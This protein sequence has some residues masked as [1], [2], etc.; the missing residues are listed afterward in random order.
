MC[1]GFEMKVRQVALVVVCPKVPFKNM[2]QSVTT[3][4]NMAYTFSEYTYM[5]LDCTKKKFRN[6]VFQ[7]TQRLLFG[8]LMRVHHAGFALRVLK[9]T[10]FGGLKKARIQPQDPKPVILTLLARPASGESCLNNS[11]THTTFKKC[12]AWGYQTIL[13]AN[14]FL[15]GTFRWLK[16]RTLRCCS[17]K[18]TQNGIFNSQLMFGME[19]LA[20]L[21]LVLYSFLR[22]LTVKNTRILSKINY[23]GFLKKFHC[24][25]VVSC[26]IN[27]TGLLPIF[28]LTLLSTKTRILGSDLIKFKCLIKAITAEDC[29]YFSLDAYRN[30]C[31]SQCTRSWLRWLFRGLQRLNG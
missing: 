30:P 24:K 3:T 26:D 31:S 4:A 2:F 22:D 15:I 17:S 13:Y 11:C 20:T 19:S 8:L 29:F 21:S 12:S 7:L 6:N 9:K 18:F 5:L 1:F 14:S 16:I 28:L 23:Q 25:S 10:S 27:M